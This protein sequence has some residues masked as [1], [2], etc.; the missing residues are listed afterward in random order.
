MTE[1]KLET[2]KRCR[3]PKCRSKL[4]EPVSNDREAFCCVGCYRAFYRHHC[5]I[6]EEEFE[7]KNEAQKVCRTRKCVNAF[8]QLK[9]DNS[10]LGRYFPRSTSS[11]PSEM[12]INQGSAVAIAD[13][14]TAVSATCFDGEAEILPV[15][16]K[17]WL[18]KGLAKPMPNGKPGWQWRRMTGPN[19]EMRLDDDW[20]LIDRDGK[21]VARIRQEGAGYWV[22]RPRMIPEAPIESLNAACRRAVT[23]AMA[24][25]EPWPETERHPVHPGMTVSQFKA[26]C[27]DWRS[28][29]PDLSDEE[30]EQRIIG[31]LKPLQADCIIKRHHPPVNIVGGYRFPGAPVID[32]SPTREAELS[33]PVAPHLSDATSDKSDFADDLSIP[34]FL[35]RTPPQE[36]L[37]EAA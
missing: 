14:R 4:P 13:D 19:G 34:D 23:A 2:R 3:N 30:I 8:R 10:A 28:K 27:R 16:G 12:P 6:C 26:T 25:L 18:P 17:P 15:Q 32:L 22:A 36:E 20:E 33:D 7:R 9:K 21:M 1:F 35:R 31:I 11:A 5:V 24:T 37:R 29:Y